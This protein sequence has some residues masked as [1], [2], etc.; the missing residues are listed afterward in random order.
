MAA[1][2][3]YAGHIPDKLSIQSVRDVARAVVSSFSGREELTLSELD[4]ARGSS[5]PVIGFVVFS[6]REVRPL[7]ITC[8]SYPESSVVDVVAAAVSPTPVTL[9]RDCGRCFDAELVVPPTTLASFSR[10][11][12]LISLYSPPSVADTKP[13]GGS[14][15]GVLPQLLAMSELFWY[16]TFSE[17]GRRDEVPLFESGSRNILVHERLSLTLSILFV[18]CT[19]LI[20]VHRP[21][22]EVF[23]RSILRRSSIF[24]TQTS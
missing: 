1:V 14:E 2:T 13:Q 4:A 11:L 21:L 23:H 9:S 5:D 8:R 3:G 19:E 6:L 12:P 10:P 20:F 24:E 15:S 18:L 7:I 22:S 16:R 17:I